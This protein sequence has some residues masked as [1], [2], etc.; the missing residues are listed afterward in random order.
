LYSS[1]LEQC[2]GEAFCHWINRSAQPVTLAADLHRRFV[3][4]TPVRETVAC[5]LS[6][7]PLDPVVDRHPTAIDTQ[8]NE[9]YFVSNIDM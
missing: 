7:G 6:V 3:H 9:Y 1:R 2:V 8:S 4:P 5:R